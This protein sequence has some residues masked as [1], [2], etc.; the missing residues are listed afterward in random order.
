[1]KLPT[2]TLFVRS[3]NPDWVLDPSLPYH[4]RIHDYYIEYTAQAEILT[5]HLQKYKMRIR[6][7]DA[8]GQIQIDDVDADP[9]FKKYNIEEK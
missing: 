7:K 2:I 3:R 6:Y 8:C 9:F 1:M 5:I 4:Q